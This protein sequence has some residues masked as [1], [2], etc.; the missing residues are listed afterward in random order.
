MSDYDI[1]LMSYALNCIATIDDATEQQIVKKYILEMIDMYQATAHTYRHND[2][3]NVYQTSETQA[4]LQREL[5]SGDKH[6][7][8]VLGVL[9]DKIDFSKFK[10]ETI[11]YYQE[12]FG[13]LLSFYFASYNN[14]DA[15]NKCEN[16]I[17][18]LEEKIVGVTSETVKEEL[19]KS[20]IFAITRSGGIGDWSKCQSSYSYQDKQFLNKMFSKY[21][22]YHLSELIDVVFKLHIKDLLPEVLTSIQSAFQKCIEYYGED[23]FERIVREKSSL[24]L[25]L[26]TRAFLDFNEKIKEDAKLIESFEWILSKLRDLGYTEAAVILDEFRIH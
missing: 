25:S 17:Y 8:I 14:K 3:L 15:R 21:G 22:G 18:K 12:V 6:T 7:D 20:L 19:Y 16:I 23:A 5:L 4:L 10:S 13:A 2:I 11:E 9:F 1:T 24:I 26:I